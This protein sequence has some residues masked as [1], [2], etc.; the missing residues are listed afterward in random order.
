MLVAPLVHAQPTTAPSIQ[1]MVT[2]DFP[3]EGVEVRTL[4]DIVTK[5][6]GIPILYDEAI[7]N[8]KVILRVPVQVPESALPGI[9]QSA[10]RMKGLALVD[11]EQPGWK[12]VVPAANLAAMARPTTNPA[13]NV[14]AVTLVVPLK[15]ADPTKV[16]EA[17]RGMLTQPG[18]NIHAVAG[19]R[20]IIV[21]DSSG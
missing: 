6:L 7:A 15:R 10:L 16:I 2:M 17:A 8:K 3:A 20:M 14:S 9:L 4:V 21:S 19:Q 18:G 12:Q 5:R 1:P 13:D 11:A